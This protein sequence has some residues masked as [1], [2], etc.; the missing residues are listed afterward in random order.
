MSHNE[1]DDLPD[2][3]AD[4]HDVDWA[5]ILGPT[6]PS[7]A[8]T[9]APASTHPGPEPSAPLNSPAMPSIPESNDSSM[10]FSDDMEMDTAFLAELDR[11]EE[12]LIRTG[13]MAPSASTSGPPRA[14]E[15]QNITSSSFE[16]N[17]RTVTPLTQSNQTYEEQSQ[18]HQLQNASI[19][20]STQD[21]NINLKRNG[22]HVSDIPNKRPRLSDLSHPITLRSKGKEKAADNLQLILSAYEEELTCPM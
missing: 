18:F 22:E 9:Q 5:Q 8:T 17:S 10:Y 12:T 1:F 15:V 19:A 20:S 21:I 11:L 16:Q 14:I 2:D 4:I 6:P 13:S 7:T 3:F